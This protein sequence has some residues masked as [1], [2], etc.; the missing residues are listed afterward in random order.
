MPLE[1][2]RLDEPVALARGDDA[3][4]PAP[5]TGDVRM[6]LLAT[7]GPCVRRVQAVVNTTLIKEIHCPAAGLQRG[8]ILPEAF[9]PR[10]VPLGVAQDFFLM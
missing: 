6:D 10:L 9:P 8:Q 1:D 5:R 7:R 3:R 2:H 4:A